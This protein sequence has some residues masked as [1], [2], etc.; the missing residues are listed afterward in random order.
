MS[1]GPWLGCEGR[2]SE[3]VSPTF[4]RSLFGGIRDPGTW[5]EQGGLRGRLGFGACR[6]PP[7]PPASLGVEPRKPPPSPPPRPVVPPGLSLPGR[8]HCFMDRLVSE[9][10]K[11]GLPPWDSVPISPSQ[12]T[13]GLT[14][15]HTA[16]LDAQVHT[17]FIDRS[18]G[19]ALPPTR[20][21]K[22]WAGAGGAGGSEGLRLGAGCGQDWPHCLF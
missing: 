22:G 8:V 19:A 17:G 9:G 13:A 6:P 4:A 12:L 7:S 18:A 3:G 14:V 5:E 16:G 1:P 20:T 21:L 2:H 10:G 11:Q 15:A